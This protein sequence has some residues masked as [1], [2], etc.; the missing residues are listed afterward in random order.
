L[1]HSDKFDPAW[2]WLSLNITSRSKH[3]GG[4]QSLFCDGH[5]QFIKNTIG[6]PIWQ[7]LGSA[8]GLRHR[9]AWRLRSAAGASGR[10]CC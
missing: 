4:V 1:P 6:L 9:S 8:A 7:G 2:N 10:S 3:P 5:V